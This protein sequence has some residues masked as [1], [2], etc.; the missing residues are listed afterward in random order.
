[1]RSHPSCS[2][3]SKTFDGHHDLAEHM[4]DQHPTCPQCDRQFSSPNSLFQH[5]K[6][7][8]PRTVS[9][10]I[11]GDKKFKNAANAVAHVESGYC[12]GCQGKD[13]AR[14]QIYQYVSQYAPSL[15][16][17]MIENGYSSNSVPD[18]PYECSYCSR[19]F[20]QLSAQM[21]HEGDFHRNQR[22]MRQLGW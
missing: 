8:I 18:K 9:C 12:S 4:N 13:N 22:Q 14:T 3:C 10:P 21:N 20:A 19:R 17:Q 2:F 15:R 16:V 6:A 5:S 11:C 7:H 1:M